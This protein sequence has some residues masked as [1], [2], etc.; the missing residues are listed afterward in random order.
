MQSRKAAFSKI[1]YASGLMSLRSRIFAAPASVLL[2]VALAAMTAT[3][4]VLGTRLANP[5]EIHDMLVERIDKQH[6]SD[7][8][9]VGVITKKAREI[10]SY[11]H[12]DSGDPRVPDGD[13]AYGIGSVTKVFTALL[14]ADMAEKGEVKLSDPIWKYLPDSV[15]PPE[16]NGKEITLLDLATHYSGLPIMPGNYTFG[17]TPDQLYAFVNSYPLTRDPGTKYEYSN[18]GFGLLGQLLARRAGT[19]YETLLRTRI[20]GPLGMTRTAVLPTKQMESNLAPGH[21]SNMQK[22]PV[23]EAP[24]LASAGSMRST[25]NDLLIFLAANMGIIHSPLQPAMKKMLSV[26]RPAVPGAKVAMGWHLET[27]RGGI[28]CHNGQNN[29]YYSFVGYDPHRKIGVVVLSNSTVPI[30]DIGW[31]IF[32]YPPPLAEEHVGP[33]NLPH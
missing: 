30:D 15:Y 17:Y 31:R 16:H 7:A 5:E 13:T 32:S 20:T 11:G 9:V 10:I 25:A 3:G 29:G 21:K 26:Q 18:F 19:D 2:F 27:G 8:M 1:E 22:H 4:Q 14:L 6:R 28:I 23:W 12:F 24:G 33:S